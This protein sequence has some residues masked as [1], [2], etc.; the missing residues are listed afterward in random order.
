MIRELHVLH[1]LDRTLY[2][3]VC[4]RLGLDAER[5]INQDNKAFFA[6]PSPVRPFMPIISTMR[7]LAPLTF[8]IS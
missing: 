5:K 2:E 4:S 3:A 1:Y 6:P 7:P 8:W